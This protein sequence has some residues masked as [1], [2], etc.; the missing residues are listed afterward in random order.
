MENVVS[1]DF[2]TINRSYQIRQ[3]ELRRLRK[4]LDALPEQLREFARSSYQHNEDL[5]R[6][7]LQD[8]KMLTICQLHKTLKKKFIS[9][10]IDPKSY[11]I[12][13]NDRRTYG[14]L[15]SRLFLFMI[16]YLRSFY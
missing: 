12:G 16:D 7:K 5:K 10:G 2:E 9:D 15:R 4:Q 6:K 14:N 8:S 3:V 13:G 11:R 1:K